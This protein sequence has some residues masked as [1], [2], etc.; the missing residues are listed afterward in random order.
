MNLRNGD[1][2]VYTDNDV[3]E[4]T[5]ITPGSHDPLH[6]DAGNLTRDHNGYEYSY[7][8]ENRLSEIT[9]GTDTVA[10]YTYDAMGRRIEKIEYDAYGR[11]GRGAILEV[12]GPIRVGPIFWLRADNVLAL[13]G[14]FWYIAGK[15]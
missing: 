13:G 9:D 2:E 3:N 8:Y 7:D 5:D 1:G 11:F 10:V 14:D 12:L 15:R 6:D 4:Y